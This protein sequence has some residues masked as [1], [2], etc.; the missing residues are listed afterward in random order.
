LTPTQFTR[1]KTED[2]RILFNTAYANTSLDGSFPCMILF[3]MLLHVNCMDR[4]STSLITLGV[5]NI[6]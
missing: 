2:K 1:L 5:R 3:Q 4:H 6:D